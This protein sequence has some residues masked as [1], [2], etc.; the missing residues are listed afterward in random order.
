MNRFNQAAVG[1]ELRMIELK[2]EVNEL[3]GKLGEPAR[4]R[5]VGDE[6]AQA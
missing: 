4:H 1:R 5:I 6:T 2:C 3:C